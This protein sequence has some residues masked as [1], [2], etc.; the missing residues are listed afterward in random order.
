VVVL[1]QVDAEPVHERA[2]VFPGVPESRD[3]FELSQQNPDCPPILRCV[4]WA[5]SGDQALGIAREERA[6]LIL[7]GLWH[8]S[9]PNGE[10]RGLVALH[11]AGGGANQP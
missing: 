1:W 10:P 3:R 9:R 4:V 2:Y 7:S 5:A 8:R 6:R 11:P